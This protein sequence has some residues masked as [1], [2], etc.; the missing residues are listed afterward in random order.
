M[1]DLYPPGLNHAALHKSTGDM[2]LTDQE[3]TFENIIVAM[4]T[5]VA[6][7]RAV[8]VTITSTATSGEALAIHA[9]T[10]A[11]NL[12]GDLELC[13]LVA[14]ARVSAG[15][16]TGT[17]KIRGAR[18]RFEALAASTVGGIA[19]GLHID[20]RGEAGVTWS[21]DVFGIH[22]QSHM[23]TISATAQMIRLEE[24]GGVTW[25]DLIAAH[26]GAGSDCEFFFYGSPSV[27]TGWSHLEDKT[28]L[29][30]KG[31]LRVSVGLPRYI[32]LYG[33]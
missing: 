1:T 28:G 27:C 6:Y 26:F 25:D 10:I 3:I 14:I 29:G 22:I 19:T 16:D 2:P 24:N 4:T 5:A 17:G 18:V 30:A 7:A 31:W 32:Q 21:A 11:N 15:I 33:P 23:Q 13:G 9:I 20:L 12:S 8:D